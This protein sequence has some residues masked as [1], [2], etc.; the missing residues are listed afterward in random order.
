MQTFHD[1]VQYRQWRHSIDGPVVFVP[2]MGALHRG[3]ASLVALARQRAGLQGSVVASIFVNPLQFGAGEDFSRY[4]RTIQADRELLIA[5]R[6]DVLFAPDAATMYPAGH[7]DIFV[8]PG[9]IGEIWEGA[10]RPGHFQGVCTVV[11]K[12]LNIILPTHMILGQKD[13]QQHVILAQM[14]EHLNFPVEL[15]IAPTMREP[16]GLAMSSRNRYLTADERQRAPA[17]YRT[18]CWAVNE[19]RRGD[20]DAAQLGEDI[21]QR[22]DTA[23][24]T[25]RYA[26]ICSRHTLAAVDGKVGLQDVIL[27]AAK[28]GTTRLIDNMRID[29]NV[30]VTGAPRE[31]P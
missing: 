15:I 25:T 16:D 4:P 27:I 3:H 12:L 23:G 6:A 10:D 24:L 14:M 11:A 30:P 17:I 9:K 29:E 22:I 31:M 21:R 1:I 8:L 26:A 28:L 13:F 19:A 5:Q 7:C 18:L 20:C 2:T